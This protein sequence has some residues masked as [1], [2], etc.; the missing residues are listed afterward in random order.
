MVL[1]RVSELFL[2]V[3][4]HSHIGEGERFL[5]LFGHRIRLKPSIVA[6][7]SRRVTVW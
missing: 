7:N 1:E 2:A 4:A 3:G 6:R 5:G